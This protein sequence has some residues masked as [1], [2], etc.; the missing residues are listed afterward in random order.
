[1]KMSQGRIQWLTG[2]SGVEPSESAVG[3]RLFVTEFWQS[4]SKK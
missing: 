4:N 1:M 2:I 3:V